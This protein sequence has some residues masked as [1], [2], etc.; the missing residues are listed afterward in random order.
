VPESFGKVDKTTGEY[1][2]PEGLKLGHDGKFV[3]V[4]AD[5]YIKSQAV[6]KEEK[7]EE[8][9][10]DKKEDKKEEKK[11]EKKDEKKDDKKE[12]KKEEI[13]GDK[14][15]EGKEEAKSPANSANVT[16][17]EE[18][19]PLD[20]ARAP[21]SASEIT[22]APAHV[23]APPAAPLVS[24]IIEVPKIYEARPEMAKFV[25]QYAVV[26]APPVAP[27]I[28]DTQRN[29]AQTQITKTETVRQTAT[30]TGTTKTTTNVKIIF[31]AQ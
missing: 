19:K 21:A 2:A 13:T 3:V 29:I 18:V 7:K 15:I 23:A 5:A 8:K 27:I 25:D 9:K 14:K 4:D 1:K 10:E 31:N 28:T 24:I 11:E 26:K 30:D 16:Q 6:N 17:S 22:S 20:N 12:E